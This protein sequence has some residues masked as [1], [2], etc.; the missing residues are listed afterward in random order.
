VKFIVTFLISFSVFILSCKQKEEL[1]TEAEVL[2]VIEKFDEG[3]KNKKAE[4]VDF[5][6]IMFISL[7]QE[8]PSIVRI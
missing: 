4:L 7:N 3:W 2:H 6:K 8:I 1:L 5:L